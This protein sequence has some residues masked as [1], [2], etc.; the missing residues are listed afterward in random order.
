MLL[1]VCAGFARALCAVL[2][3]EGRGQAELMVEGGEARDLD[4]ARR[5]LRE[6]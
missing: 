5:I 3:G 6:R 2:T 4:H 1:C